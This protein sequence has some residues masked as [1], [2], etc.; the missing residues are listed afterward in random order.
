MKTLTW[1]PEARGASPLP[2]ELR[3]RPS[4]KAVAAAEDAERTLRLRACALPARAA[5]PRLLLGVD[6]SARSPGRWTWRP[7][8]LLP[9][10]FVKEGQGAHEDGDRLEPVI[11]DIEVRGADAGDT[12]ATPAGA[13]A[14]MH[15]HCYA[16]VDETATTGARRSPA[17]TPRHRGP[18]DGCRRLQHGPPVARRDGRRC[19]PPPSPPPLP[20]DERRRGSIGFS[21]RGSKSLE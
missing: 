16:L 21:E 6:P 18:G 1:R 12:H 7:R 8:I 5:S 2:V 3:A 19:Q 20:W 11:I 17:P 13:A 14:Y 15:N 4:T 10:T 9:S